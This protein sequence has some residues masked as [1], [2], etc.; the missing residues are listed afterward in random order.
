MAGWRQWMLYM[1]YP[2]HFA[3][4]SYIPQENGEKLL[5]A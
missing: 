3:S 1:S 2:K 5:D 4:G